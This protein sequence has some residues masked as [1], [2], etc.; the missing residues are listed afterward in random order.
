MSNWSVF[1]GYQSY[2]PGLL[3]LRLSDCQR[4]FGGYLRFDLHLY[5]RAGVSV[6]SA[7]PGQLIATLKISATTDFLARL[8][9]E[10]AAEKWLKA[11]LDDLCEDKVIFPPSGVTP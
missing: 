4:E 10:R 2:I 6:G 8:K 9:A 5:L 3:E 1:P 7:V 11:N